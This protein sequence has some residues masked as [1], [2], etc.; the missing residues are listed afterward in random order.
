MYGCETWPLRREDVHRLKVFDHHCLW[1]LS[2]VGWR[3]GVGN[4]TECKCVSG[5]NESDVLSMRIKWCR[6]Q[7][8][9]HVLHVS[10]LHRPHWTPYSV[11]KTNAEEVFRGLIDDVAAWD[12]EYYGLF[13]QSGIVKF[14]WS[15]PIKVIRW[16]TGY[17]KRYSNES[18]EVGKFFSFLISSVCLNIIAWSVRLTFL[19]VG[20]DGEFFFCLR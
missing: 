6:H 9:G 18:W 8:L 16:V 2:E 13:E 5:E 12:G 3:D 7:W 11:Q 19:F 1:H 20:Q 4:L 17:F 10:T 14:T 15:G